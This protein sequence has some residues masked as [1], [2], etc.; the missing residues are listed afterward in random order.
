M[1]GD[2]IIVED[3]HRAAAEG[4]AD[5]VLPTIRSSK[6]RYR[7]TIAG[8][9]GGG[10]SEIA[11]ALAGILDQAGVNAVILQQDDY[12]VY[13]PKSNDQA[14]RRDIAWVGLQE[15]H[16]DLLDRHLEAFHEAAGSIEKPLVIYE[17]D[18]IITEQLT[19]G[20]ARVA[21]AEGTYTTQLANADCRV[22]IDRDYRDTKKHRERRVRD[23]SELDPFI[24]QVL[25]IE[26]GLI[27]AHKPKADIIV[28]KDYSVS[29]AH[30][31]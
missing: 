19:F 14:R 20:E 2:S 15:V 30:G 22:F 11:S 31:V 16:L 6:R 29:R 27:S 4:I 8:E 26:H 3:Y 5:I 7:I 18:Q 21:I 17:D 25:L 13:P 23:A 10:K 9:S 28:N 24:D 1:R 12:F